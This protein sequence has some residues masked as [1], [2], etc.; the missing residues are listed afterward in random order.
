MDAYVCEMR[1]I[2][3]V[4]L[5]VCLYVCLSVCLSNSLSVCQSVC[6][7]VCLCLWCP[8]VCLSVCLSVCGCVHAGG[9]VCAHACV[10]VGKKILHNTI[11][12]IY[13]IHYI[14]SCSVLIRMSHE[15]EMWFIS[16]LQMLKTRCITHYWVFM[17][18]MMRSD[19]KCATNVWR[20]I[21]IVNTNVKK[22][23]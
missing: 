8:S 5:S 21:H 19:L 12:R 1:V 10:R 4:C 2:N 11:L 23:L 7:T 15:C 3:N 13:D 6:R 17:M 14:F 22:N 9:H 18:R 20:V 16:S